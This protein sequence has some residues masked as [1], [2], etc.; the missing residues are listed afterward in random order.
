M[1]QPER[2]MTAQK[3]LFNYLRFS[4]LSINIT[5]LRCRIEFFKPAND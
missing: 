2:L 5:F 3:S 4:N 1:T